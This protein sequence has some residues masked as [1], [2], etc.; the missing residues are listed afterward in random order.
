MTEII[1]A[2]MN[3]C[4]PDAAE[5]VLQAALA[6]LE[7]ASKISGFSILIGAAMKEFGVCCKAAFYDQALPSCYVIFVML[8][9]LTGGRTKST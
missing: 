1:E 7:L 3:L 4:T 9:V 2:N 5:S 8:V 6:F